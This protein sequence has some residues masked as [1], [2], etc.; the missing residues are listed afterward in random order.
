MAAIVTNTDL[1]SREYEAAL[2]VWVEGD[3]AFDHIEDP[4]RDYRE[5]LATDEGLHGWTERIFELDYQGLTKRV[6]LDR[7]MLPPA[8]MHRRVA[9][10]VADESLVAPLARAFQL[11]CLELAKTLFEPFDEAPGMN[12]LSARLVAHMRARGWLDGARAIEESERDRWQAEDPAERWLFWIDR[13]SPV[14]CRWAIWVANELHRLEM[15]PKAKA[16][17][18]R[19][20]SLVARPLAMIS[21][22]NG[23][24]VESELAGFERRVAALGP[25]PLMRSETAQSLLSDRGRRVLVALAVHLATEAHRN[26]IRKAPS[27]TWVEFPTSVHQLQVLWNMRTSLNDVIEALEYLQGLSF[28]G[29]PAVLSYQLREVRARSGGRPSKMALVHCGAPLMPL[30]LDGALRRIGAT[31][32]P[33]DLKWNCFVL[34]WSAAPT[35]G[36]RRTLT[37]QR[38]AFA[39]GIGVI[40]TAHREEYAEIGLPADTSWWRG[41]L[42]KEYDLYHRGHASLAD[43]LVEA[44]QAHPA[45]PLPGTGLPTAPVFVETA[46]GSGRLILGPDYRAE[47]RVVIEAAQASAD[48]RRSREKRKS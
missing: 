9:I 40:L 5:S 2:A 23:S 1:L 30:E 8:E 37:K 44:W 43:S 20:R 4:M 6:K 25:V 16:P 35:I 46:P 34:P 29:E 11:E 12:P 21:A 33:E 31:S 17:V 32:L 24:P 47:H 13:D 22:P 45:P 48:G 19:L 42:V 41:Q 39:L 28:A 38:C 10:E 15:E 18:P 36:N 7:C 3:P 14:G 27:P 26:W